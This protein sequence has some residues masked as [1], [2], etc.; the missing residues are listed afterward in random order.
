M[1]LSFLNGS[2]REII[3]DYGHIIHCKVVPRI[4]QINSYYPRP[5]CNSAPCC[6]FLSWFSLFLPWD[7]KLILRFNWFC[8]NWLQSNEVDL[9]PCEPLPLCSEATL[10]PSSPL[11]PLRTIF[12]MYCSCRHFNDGRRCMRNTNLLPPCSFGASDRGTAALVFSCW[13]T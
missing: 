2:N 4:T 7:G 12:A 6:C 10:Y 8:S 1:P 5:F 11:Q 9:F 3:T 13:L